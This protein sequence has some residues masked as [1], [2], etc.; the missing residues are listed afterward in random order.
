MPSECPNCHENAVDSEPGGE[1]VC[2]ECGAVVESRVFNF[3]N[4]GD[5][6]T[7]MRAD[8]TTLFV[9]DYFELPR[10]MRQRLPKVDSTPTKKFLQSCLYA[11]VKRLNLSKEILDKTRELLFDKVLPARKSRKCQGLFFRRS[12]LVGSCVFIVCRQN[13]IQFTYR[14]MAEVAECNMFHIGKCVKNILK[15]LDI[16]LDP[17]SVES[18]VLCI[19]SELSVLDRSC[20]KLSLDLWQIFKSFGL[21]ISRN[22]AAKAVGLV[23]LVLEYKRMSP[24]K[25]EIAEVLGKNSVTELEL[26]GYTS[27][28]K[29]SLLELA[30]EV[31]WI[32]D[33]VKKKD[34]VKHVA[35]IVNFHKK[36][37]KL[38]LSVV[39]ALWMKKK[40]ITDKNRKAKIQMAKSRI[41][42]KEQVESGSSANSDQ[43]TSTL[44]DLLSRCQN[45]KHRASYHGSSEGSDDALALQSG[46][47]QEM[48]TLPSTDDGYI[49][50]ESANSGILTTCNKSGLDHNDKLIEHLL[51]CGY[52]EEELMDGYFESRIC[53]LQ[54]SKQLDPKGEREDLDEMD[55]ADIEMHHYLWSVAEME[56]LKNLQ[57]NIPID[58]C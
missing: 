5:G 29:T 57:Q 41:L 16:S 23:L 30:K 20:E 43:N 51:T 46:P 4:E 2:H 34:I 17:F 50:S 53:D 56:R 44:P 45:C 38:D 35:E 32:P 3:E 22:Q 15:A 37:G 39:K 31:P 12:V 7:A 26:R 55:I 28:V 49:S 36:C 6:F 13:N 18:L 58:N 47:S 33:S 14:R 27:R 24:S 1:L 42:D 25:E 19:L 10:T 40:E 54:S 8:G 21:S 52:S 48:F 11:L 9:G